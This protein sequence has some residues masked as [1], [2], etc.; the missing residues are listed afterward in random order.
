M[1][2]VACGV[3]LLRIAIHPYRPYRVTDCESVPQQPEKGTSHEEVR[4]TFTGSGGGA[5]D[6]GEAIQLCLLS[7]KILQLAQPARSAPRLAEAG[8]VRPEVERAGRKFVDL[9]KGTLPFGSGIL[10]WILIGLSSW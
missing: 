3:R 1:S 10:A 5:K 9:N 6:H 7:T 2:L 4:P 8:G